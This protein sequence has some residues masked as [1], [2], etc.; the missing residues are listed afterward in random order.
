MYSIPSK[1]ARQAYKIRIYIMVDGHLSFVNK[2]RYIISTSPKAITLLLIN[3]IVLAG[4]WQALAGRDHT[5]FK[6]YCSYQRVPARRR[7]PVGTSVR[8]TPN[9]VLATRDAGLDIVERSLG[10]RTVD[11]LDFS[12]SLAESFC[13][14]SMC[15][16]RTS[17]LQRMR[18]GDIA[19]F[20]RHRV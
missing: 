18:C 10:H 5:L 1:C 4:A 6:R 17:Y 2:W 8:T 16:V 15:T 12:L 13:Q 11:Y 9:S 3:S 7:I 19:Q 20:V 14:R